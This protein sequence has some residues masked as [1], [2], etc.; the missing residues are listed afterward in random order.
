MYAPELRRI[1]TELR[2][3]FR[4]GF[5]SGLLMGIGLAVLVMA[6]YVGTLS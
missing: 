3:T 2:R 4:D 6:V 5:W 1:E